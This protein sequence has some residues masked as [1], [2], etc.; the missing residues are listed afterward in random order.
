MTES[1]F[2]KLVDDTLLRIEQAIDACGVDIDYET[3]AGILELEFENGTR[4]IINRQGATQEIWV[5]AKAGGFHFAWKDDAWCNTRDGAELFAM[6]SVL[7]SGQA[8]EEV[9]LPACRT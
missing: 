4:I 9:V 5:A 2:N 8:N 3:A 1:E 7:A 6:L